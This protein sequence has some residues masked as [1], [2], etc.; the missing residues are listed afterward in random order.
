[1]RG[2]FVL[3]FSAAFV[4]VFLLLVFLLVVLGFILFVLFVH[5]AAAETIGVI[6]VFRGYSGIQF[7]EGGLPASGLP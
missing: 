6:L 4:L 1:M 7:S 3:F 5:A 2:V